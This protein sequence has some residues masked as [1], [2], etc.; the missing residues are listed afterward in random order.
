MAAEKAARMPAFHRRERARWAENCQVDISGI[1]SHMT[2]KCGGNIHDRGVVEITA[3]SVYQDYDSSCAPRNA[4][5]FGGKVSEFASKNK[6]DQWI[7]WDFKALRIEPTHYTLWTWEGDLNEH[8]LQ[9]WAVEESDDGASWTEIDRRENPSDLNN[10][11]AVKTFAVA[12]SG[13]FRRIR[14]RQTG[15]NHRDGSSLALSVFEVFG[16]VAGLQ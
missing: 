6:P 2:M 8:H 13:S 12:R 1:I 7:F 3:S 5:D 4:A 14:L 9:S 11:S 16:A 15:P 10:W